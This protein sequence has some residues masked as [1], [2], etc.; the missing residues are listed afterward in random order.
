MAKEL[1]TTFTFFCLSVYPF[2]VLSRQGSVGIKHLSY[3]LSYLFLKSLSKQRRGKRDG[4]MLERHRTKIRP[5][6]ELWCWKSSLESLGLQGD[7]TS[8]S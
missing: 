3:L 4:C 8:Q 2:M 1:D 5:Y 6:A 7:Q